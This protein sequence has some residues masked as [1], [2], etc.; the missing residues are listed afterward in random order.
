MDGLGLTGRLAMW[1]ARRRWIVLGVWVVLFLVG[2]FLSAGIS[3]VVNNDQRQ[4]NNPE[5]QQASNL[6]EDRGLRDPQPIEELVIVQFETATV[7]DAAFESTVTEVLGEIRALGSDVV[8]SATSFFETG[9]PSLVSEDGRTTL[10]PVTLVGTIADSTD[11][12]EPF[13]ER[14]RELNAAHDDVTVGMFGFGSLSVVFQEF[15]EEDLQAESRVLPVALLI[16]ILVFGAVAAGFVPIIVAFIAI[17]IAIGLAAV[18][19]EQWPLSFFIPNFILSIGLAVGIDYSLFIV[20]R[21]R[22]ER[23]QGREKFDAIG[24]A[25]D[26]ASRAVLFSGITVIIALFG[27]FIVPQAIFRSLA[28]G[29]VLVAALS[30]I[31]GLT[32]QPALLAILGDRVNFARVRPRLVAAIAVVMGI[33]AFVL[34]GA[35]LDGLAVAALATLL[36]TLIVTGIGNQ[37]RLEQ[38]SGFVGQLFAN[39]RAD[40]SG[41]FWATIA[42][43][44][45]RYPLF[46]A[47]SAAGLLVLLS[48]SYWSISLG[49]AGASTLPIGSEPREGFEAL[50]ADFSVGQASPAEIV[51]DAADTGAA[52][53]QGAI[54]SLVAALDADP[55]FGEPVNAGLDS[56]TTVLIQVALNV[57]SATPEERAAIERLRGELIPA[58]FA[59]VNADVLVGGLPG[60]N[61][62]FFSMVDTYTPIVFAFVLGFSFVLLLLVFRSIV[63]PIKAI[64]MNLLS[65]GA[66]YGLLVLVFQE[67]VGADLLGFETVETVE[68]WIPLFLFTI[69]FGLSMDYHV[70]L[71]SRIR[72]RYDQTQENGESV[73]F[74]LRSTANIITGAAAIMIA[75]F[76]GFAAGRLVSFQQ[77]GFGLSA[78]IFLDATVVRTILVPATMA[79]LGD[80]NWYL[81]SWLT[82]LPDLRVERGS[83][84]P[85]AAPAGGGGD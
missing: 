8:K 36:V 1:S 70:F 74:G 57:E 66:A 11:S 58:A 16:L 7:D 79:L 76:G 39:G 83:S 56:T 35:G 33:P 45:M 62:D 75:V 47:G 18:I 9:A 85:A 69:L 46:A 72:E 28:T 30:V 73:A 82:W 53:V 32:L 52:E 34:L 64:I 23:A 19:G 77:M 61:A 5:S 65:V 2:G 10:I 48:L 60:G 71:L 40:E 50:A 38:R 81:P 24:I 29:A 78:A 25:G 55:I 14:V 51:I 63:V 27:M 54:D 20:E 17:V 59:G 22:E 42:R 84:A 26:T 31:A 80:R 15:A 43:V 4:T 21:Y 13:V 67:G 37:Q 49:F 68:A 12:S 6:L 3:D 44:V 41:G